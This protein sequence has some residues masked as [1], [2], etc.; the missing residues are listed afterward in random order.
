MAIMRRNA[1]LK[2]RSTKARCSCVVSLPETS[3]T[4]MKNEE[5]VF[6]ECTTVPNSGSIS[7]IQAGAEARLGTFC[8]LGGTDKPAGG[9]PGAPREGWFRQSR[10][11]CRMRHRGRLH[12]CSQ[13]WGACYGTGPDSRVA[14][15]SARK[16][17]HLA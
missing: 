5:I 7:P 8:S 12:H 15:A 10:A 1:A 4:L 9:A 6:H 17:S 2:G 14:A 3:D 13:A 11:G 16:C